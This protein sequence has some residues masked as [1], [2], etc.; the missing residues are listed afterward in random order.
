MQAQ[1]YLHMI[2]TSIPAHDTFHVQHS[3]EECV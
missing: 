3:I 2:G 1:V